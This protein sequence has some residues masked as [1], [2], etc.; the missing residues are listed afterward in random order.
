VRGS[1]VGKPRTHDLTARLAAKR[2]GAFGSFASRFIQHLEKKGAGFIMN[3]RSDERGIVVRGKFN[4]SLCTSLSL[5]ESEL[6]ICNFIRRP[7]IIVTSIK[8]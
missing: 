7:L 8:Q 6:D 1:Y 5:M 4:S 3:P 2:V